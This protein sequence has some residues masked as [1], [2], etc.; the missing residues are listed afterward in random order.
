MSLPENWLGLVIV[1]GG[2]GYNGLGGVEWEGALEP[3]VTNGLKT[4]NR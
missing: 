1:D 3:A 2:V 4:V